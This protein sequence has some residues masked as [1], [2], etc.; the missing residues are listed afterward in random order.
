M[1]YCRKHGHDWYIKSGIYD[2]AT[3]GTCGWVIRDAYL[4]YDDLP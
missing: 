2:K 4:T 3:C 1:S